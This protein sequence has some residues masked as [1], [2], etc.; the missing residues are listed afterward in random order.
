MSTITCLKE[1]EEKGVL[2]SEDIVI[3]TINKKIIEEYKVC[4]NH[5]WGKYQK[6]NGCCSNNRIFKFLKINK[7]KITEK[8]YGYNITRH[9]DSNKYFPEYRDDDFPAITRLVAE[10][11][12]II[13]EQKTVFT[14]FTRFEIME[15]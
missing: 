7:I 9:S 2:E 1:L 13:E 14:K 5:L 12:R 15:I 10:L 4:I 8:A 3:F 11:Y 6:K